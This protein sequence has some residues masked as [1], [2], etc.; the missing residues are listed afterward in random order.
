MVAHRTSKSRIHKHRFA[1]FASLPAGPYK[2]PTA[3]E[4]FFKAGTPTETLD[5]IKVLFTDI[6]KPPPT[7]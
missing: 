4:I 7:P 5:V 2:T 1:L 6:V 3:L